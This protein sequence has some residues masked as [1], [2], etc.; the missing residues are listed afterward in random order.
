M[1]CLANHQLIMS[2]KKRSWGIRLMRVGIGRYFSRL[3]NGMEMC[4]QVMRECGV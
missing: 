1:T 4:S 2:P 3:I